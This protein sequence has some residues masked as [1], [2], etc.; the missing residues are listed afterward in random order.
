MGV[1]VTTSL[2]LFCK[3][4]YQSCI[5]TLHIL[6]VP[7]MLIHRAVCTAASGQWH[8]KDTVTIPSVGKSDG[9]RWVQEGSAVKVSPSESRQGSEI[10]C[11]STWDGHFQRLPTK[12]FVSDGSKDSFR[13]TTTSFLLFNVHNHSIKGQNVTA[14][15]QGSVPH[16]IY[17]LNHCIKHQGHGWPEVAM[18]ALSHGIFF[19]PWLFQC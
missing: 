11:V 8:R 6:N 13:Q 5:A 2:F 15:F 4:H 9:Q 17:I 1:I 19:F 3:H 14:H 18:D 12:D 16:S 10:N 7:V